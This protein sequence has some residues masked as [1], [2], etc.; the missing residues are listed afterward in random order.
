M[1]NF[2]NL[3]S[4]QVSC[5]LHGEYSAG[6][7]VIDKDDE[8]EITNDWTPIACTLQTSALSI[9]TGGVVTADVAGST[10]H[11]YGIIE[12]GSSAEGAVQ[13]LKSFKIASFFSRLQNKPVIERQEGTIK[14]ALTQ[15]ALGDCGIPAD[16]FDFSAMSAAYTFTGLIYGENVLTEMRKLAQS[17]SCYLFVNEQGKLIAAPWKDATSSVDYTIPDAFITAAGKELTPAPPTALVTVRGAYNRDIDGAGNI[18]LGKSALNNVGVTT[19]AVTRAVSDPILGPSSGLPTWPRGAEQGGLV[20]LVSG[21]PFSLPIWAFPPTQT[22]KLTFSPDTKG[23]EGIPLEYAAKSNFTPGELWEHVDTDSLTIT[24]DVAG[25]EGR[26]IRVT[27]QPKDPST[28]GC[29]VLVRGQYILVQFEPG[30][31][32]LT[33]IASAINGDLDASRQITAVGAGSQPL[34]QRFTMRL[35]D[36]ESAPEQEEMEYRVGISSPGYDPDEEREKSSAARLGGY[37]TKTDLD[38]RALRDYVDSRQ[39]RKSGF[40]AGGAR[41]GQGDND[42][43]SNEPDSS[44]VEATLGDC[45]TLTTA[46]IS[47]AEIDNEYIQTPTQADLVGLRYMQET[48]MDRHAYKVNMLYNPNIKLNDVVEFNLPQTGATIRG[49][50][51]DLSINYSA[52][53]SATMSLTVQNVLALGADAASSNLIAQ[54]ELAYLGGTVWVTSSAVAYKANYTADTIA[55]VA[56]SPSGLTDSANGFVDAGFMVGQMVYIQ[57]AAKVENAGR[58]QIASVAAGLIQFESQYSVRSEAAGSSINVRH[59]W[60]SPDEWHYVRALSG[61]IVFE[62]ESGKT[63]SVQQT[64]ITIPGKTYKFYYSANRV[65]GAGTLTFTAGSISTTLNPTNAQEIDY[66]ETTVASGSSII[67][68]W[69]A[70]G[71]SRWEISKIQA[72]RTN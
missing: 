25:S 22:P 14:E 3:V 55:I 43:Q 13:K 5:S 35:L 57:G 11:I 42:Y 52:G 24:A 23:V 45:A 50:V 58:F 28:S 18:D 16:L 4:W 39:T 29:L 15:I 27:V 49:P 44:R 67:V 64:L 1:S 70:S 41:A 19:G 20:P 33:D 17:A 68:K 47:R 31:S 36:S 46:G 53:P 71:I 40:P 9:Q 60:L 66:T 63:R 72:R 12:S 69:E 2:V 62:L 34:S 8:Y 59:A 6:I 21:K 30:V 10:Q 26:W 51:V 54:P 7:G 32:T 38:L 61:V 65:S 48:T 37:K 56:G